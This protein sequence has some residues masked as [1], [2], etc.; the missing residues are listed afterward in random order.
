MKTYMPSGTP[1]EGKWYVVDAEGKIFGRLAS[2]VA[3]I[4]RGKH[5]VD[6]TPHVAGGDH[7]IVVNIDK[8]VFTGRKLDQKMYRRHSGYPGGLKET[9]YRDLMQRKPAFAF[10]VAVKGML[11]KNSLGDVMFR[12]LKV[13]AGSEHAHSA[14]MPEPLEF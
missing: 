5:K 13:Y 10:E 11:P 8:V 3:H 7:V 2:Q 6:F 14:Q 4:L 9:S 1:A 12:K